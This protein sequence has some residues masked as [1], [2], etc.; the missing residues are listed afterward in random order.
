M[1]IKL[2]LDVYYLSKGRR[3]LVNAYKGKTGMK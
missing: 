1:S 3:H 2:Q